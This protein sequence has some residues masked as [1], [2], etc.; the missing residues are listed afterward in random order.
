MLSL[1]RRESFLGGSSRLSLCEEMRPAGLTVN[2]ESP[3]SRTLPGGGGEGGVQREG[4]GG[5]K[6]RQASAA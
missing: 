5:L 3:S 2:E 6:D 1:L 4:K